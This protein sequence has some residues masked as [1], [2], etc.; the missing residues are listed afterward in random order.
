MIPQ[1]KKTVENKARL[2]QGGAVIWHRKPQQTE[3]ITTSTN[4]SHE[5]PKKPAAQNIAKNRMDLP[6]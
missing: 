3:N 5:I 4:K 1:I 6:A 2:G